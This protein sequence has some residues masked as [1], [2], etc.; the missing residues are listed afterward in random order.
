MLVKHKSD[1]TCPT[2]NGFNTLHC[3]C[4]I[5][6]NEADLHN[7]HI[8]IIKCYQSDYGLFKRQTISEKKF[9]EI[10]TLLI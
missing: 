9:A 5:L 7:F 4:R 10:K 6:G 8:D 2:T 3:F 1:T